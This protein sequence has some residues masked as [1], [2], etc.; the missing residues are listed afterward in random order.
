VV[1]LDIFKINFHHLYRIFF[2]IYQFNLKNHTIMKWTFLL[3]VSVAAF[4]FCQV[5]SQDTIVLRPGPEGKDSQI[6]DIYPSVPHGNTMVFKSMAWTHSGVPGLNR[7]LIEWDLSLLS[8][9]TVILDARL[10][11]YFA[12]FE[13][14]YV[15]HTGENSSYLL[16]I[17]EPWD[18]ATVTWN[19]QPSTSM[20]NP[21][22]LPQSTDPE[23]DYTDIDVTQMIQSMVSSPEDNHG[24]MLQLI[25]EQY[26]RCLMFA[27]GDCEDQDKWPKLVIIYDTCAPPHSEFTYTAEELD[28]Y[29][30]DSSELADVYYWDFGDGYYS[31]LTDPWHHYQEEGTYEVCLT[32]WNDCYMNTLCQWIEVCEKP[33][34][35]FTFTIEGLTAFF[36]DQ[37][38]KAES[39]YWDF[40]DGYYS[41]L[42]NPVHIYDSDENFQVCQMTF[43]EC[44]SDT[45]C[46]ILYLY[47]VAI[48]E[49]AGMDFTVFPNPARDEVFIRSNIPGPGELI[50]SD[51]SGKEIRRQDLN[52]NQQEIIRVPLGD[53]MRGIYILKL[54]QGRECYYNKLIVLR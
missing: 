49:S 35:A 26:Y 10:N 47:A 2:Y 7:A 46:E 21:V 29:F 30:H 3:T 19:N 14:T 25:T 33:V 9:E 28:I 8:P 13:P 1:K 53:I 43:N 16:R 27:S 41:D 6:T 20:E 23:Q 34:S 51:M 4:S 42:P 15:P 45:A 38:E 22:I 11:L 32:T 44:G 12:T 48:P 31:D 37:S 5:F 24:L 54:N 17:T 50:I 39:Y 40:G 52:L 36:E 18:E